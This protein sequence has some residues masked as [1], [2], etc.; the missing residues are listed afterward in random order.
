EGEMVEGSETRLEHELDRPPNLMLWMLI[1]FVIGV[2]MSF[3]LGGVGTEDAP[4]SIN[5]I[6]A[7]TLM[8]GIFGSVFSIGAVKMATSIR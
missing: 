2:G 5:F 6:I 3:Y 1:G 4:L 7:R 8:S